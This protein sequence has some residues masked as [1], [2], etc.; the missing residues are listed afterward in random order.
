MLSKHLDQT[1]FI[2]SKIQKNTFGFWKKWRTFFSISPRDL[3][4]CMKP[5]THIWNKIGGEQNLI[6]KWKSE[7]ETL[8]VYFYAEICHFPNKS[9]NRKIFY[10]EIQFC[11]PPILSQICVGGFMQNFRTLGLI[12]KK[13]PNFFTLTHKYWKIIQCECTHYTPQFSS[14]RHTCIC[15]T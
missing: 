14:Q 6:S 9:L 15:L 10:L 4:F 11:S 12:I 13:V 7:L 8:E 2:F 5:P 1:N 3:K